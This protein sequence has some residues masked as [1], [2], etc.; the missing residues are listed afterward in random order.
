MINNKSDYIFDHPCPIRDVL[1]RISDRWSLL[2]IE[3]LA[4]KTLRF[5][6]LLHEID[7][8]SKQMLSKTL[9]CL[10]QDGFIIRTIYPERPPRVE[11]QLTAL[12]RS[13][14]TPMQHLI[15]WAD[16]NHQQICESRKHYQSKVISS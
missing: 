16:L 13:F 11:Y 3:A 9:K 1:D 12:G 8:I 10:E 5:N 6:E 15:S 7:D 4:T 2:I 14:L